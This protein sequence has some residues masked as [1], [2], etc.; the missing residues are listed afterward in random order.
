MR[1]EGEAAAT[2]RSL[3][4]RRGAWPLHEVRGAISDEPEHPI[5]IFT[6]DVEEYFH[7]SAFEGFV[8]RDRWSDLESRVDHGVQVLMDLLAEHGVHGTF[9]IL[10][11]VAER[12]PS[13]VRR[14]VSRGH[15]VASHGSSHRR[16]HTLSTG[17]F[18]EEVRSSKAILEDIAGTRVRGFR[19]PSFSIVPGSEWAF[20]VLIEEGYEYDASLFPLGRRGCG[21]PGTLTDPHYVQRRDGKILEIPIP[22]TSFF[23][24]PLPIAGGAYFRTL[25]YSLTRNTFRRYTK[26]SRIATFYIHPWEVDVEQPRVPVDF[27]TRIRHYFGLSGTRARLDRLLSEFQFT[28][29]ARRFV[30][31][32]GPGPQEL[33]TIELPG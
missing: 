28:S 24:I 31:A 3:P 17:E 22:S 9:F 14:I 16:V 4:A 10:G 18:R 27:V 23:G 11:W 29:V 8:S 12:L 30:S 26:E 2:S 15:E 13:L 21:Y 33:E 6:V 5:H 19:A 25:P 20:D 32:N 1:D 7:V